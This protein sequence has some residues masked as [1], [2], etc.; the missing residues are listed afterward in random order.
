MSI[1]GKSAASDLTKEPPP[2]SGEGVAPADGVA[3]AQAEPED[4]SLRGNYNPFDN[5]LKWVRKV[6][7]LAQRVLDMFRGP[8][9]AAF[10]A[11]AIVVSIVGILVTFAPPRVIHWIFGNHWTKFLVPWAMSKGVVRKVLD[12]TSEFLTTKLSFVWVPTKLL[13]QLMLF[14]L[15]VALRIFGNINRVRVMVILIGLQPWLVTGAFIYLRV[16]N[17]CAKTVHLSRQLIDLRSATAAVLIAVLCYATLMTVVVYTY[18]RRPPLYMFCFDEL[19]PLTLAGV[20]AGVY[21]FAAVAMTLYVDR[22]RGGRVDG[23]RAMAKDEVMKQQA[24][25]TVI[26]A[27]AGVVGV[28]LVMSLNPGYFMLRTLLSPRQINFE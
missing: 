10:L 18:M 26:A 11:A 27:A 17:F 15:I 21:V 28:Y 25:Y 19:Q 14:P 5:E 2:A 6:I 4:K 7:V 8:P 9:G 22:M 16:I 1:P 12:L 23:G 20:M 13:V 3:D 24:V